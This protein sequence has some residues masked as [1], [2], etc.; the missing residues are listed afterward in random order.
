MYFFY[1]TLFFV[2]FCFFVNFNFIEGYLLLLV[3]SSGLKSEFPPCPQGK[4]LLPSRDAFLLL[5]LLFFF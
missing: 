2:L 3:S 1:K 4:I 5:L